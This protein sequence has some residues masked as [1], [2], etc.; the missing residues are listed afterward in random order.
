MVDIDAVIRAWLGTLAGITSAFGN[1]IYA[2]RLLPPGYK[3]EQGKA[4]LFAARSGQQDF[5]SKIMTPSMQF[6][7]YGATEK[8]V[9]EGMKDL[10]DAIND[11]K[12]QKIVYC[13]MEDGT[14]PVLLTEPGTNWPYIL[15]FFRMHVRNDE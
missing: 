2:G 7:I 9:R 3:P 4:L 13:R 1:R 6:R 11:Q 12:Y 5:S 14:G 15:I 8:D 10:Y